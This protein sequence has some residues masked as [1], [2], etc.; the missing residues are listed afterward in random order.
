MCYI[1]VKHMLNNDNTPA[2]FCHIYLFLSYLIYAMNFPKRKQARLTSQAVSIKQPDSQPASQP[3][4]NPAVKTTCEP[5]NQ[6][7]SQSASLLA[8]EPA[9]NSN[10]QVASC[11]PVQAPNPLS[12]S[13]H[14]QNIQKPRFHGIHL[15]KCDIYL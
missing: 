11:A 1:K 15:T 8:S 7:A 3:S 6:I 12:K 10:N 14:E 13:T 5:N 2:C 9:N 4:R